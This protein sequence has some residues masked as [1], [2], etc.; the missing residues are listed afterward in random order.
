MIYG[1]E[2]TVIFQDYMERLEDKDF[3][4]E[5]L[6]VVPEKLKGSLIFDS[7]LEK[8]CKEVISDKNLKKSVKSLTSKDLR[9]GTLFNIDFHRVY[10]SSIYSLRGAS[11]IDIVDGKSYINSMN[12]FSHIEWLNDS[13]KVDYMFGNSS[14]FSLMNSSVSRMADKSIIDYIFDGEVD[15][16]SHNS[17]VLF[18]H[19]S[20][21]NTITN[22]SQVKFVQGESTIG[23]ISKFIG[24]IIDN[25]T[26]DNEKFATV[27]FFD[28]RGKIFSH[29]LKNLKRF[30]LK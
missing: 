13:S 18:L 20:R 1:K 25:T 4:G 11:N 19:D 23:Y 12:D 22:Y 6:L 30:F 24:P 8:I 16:M 14:I 27:I 15:K 9:L 28:G 2:N 5:G 21:V 7:D 17:S 26:M 10:N 29:P 3:T